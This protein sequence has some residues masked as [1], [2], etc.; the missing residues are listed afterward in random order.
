MTW[1]DALVVGLALTAAERDLVA[2]AVEA[3]VEREGPS[4]AADAVLEMVGGAVDL[5]ELAG[6]AAGGRDA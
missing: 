1:R 3:L 4:P 6:L 2:R 5:V